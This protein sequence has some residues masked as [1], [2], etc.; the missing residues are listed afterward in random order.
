MV[1]VAVAFDTDGGSFEQSCHVCRRDPNAR[2]RWGCDTPTDEP[3]LWIGP[4]VWCH[5][6]D[7]QCPHCHGDGRVPIY[8]C[9]RSV[10]TTGLLDVVQLT[11]LTDNGILPDTGGWQD[12]ATTFVQA[13]PVVSQEI[14]RTRAHLQ[15]QAMKRQRKPQGRS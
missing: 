14:A 2:R 12:Q 13:Y 11:V 1:A 15:E 6:R 8:R 7:D 4:C 3:Q 9:P 10:A 5:G